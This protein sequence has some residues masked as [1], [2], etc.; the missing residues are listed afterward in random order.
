VA[1]DTVVSGATPLFSRART[2]DLL[3]AI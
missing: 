3:G 1:P 2:G